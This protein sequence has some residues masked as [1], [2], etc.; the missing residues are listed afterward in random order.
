M[1]GSPETTELESR[2]K[3][4]GEAVERATGEPLRMMCPRKV[5]RQTQLS[6]PRAKKKS[7]PS[8]KLNQNLQGSSLRKSWRLRLPGK[9]RRSR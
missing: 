1:T 4:R 5:R 8:K 6:T 9:R 3:T 2:L 7:P